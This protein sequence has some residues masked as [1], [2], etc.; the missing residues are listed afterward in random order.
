MDVTMR[1]PTTHRALTCAFVGDQSLVV[2][3]VDI[4]RD[5]GLAV[6]AVASHN[7]DV[8]EAAAAHGTDLVELGSPSD[9]APAFASKQF[10]VL[11]S[12]A[13]LHILPDAVLE[14]ATTAINFHDGP[15]PDYAGLNVTSWAIANGE[16]THGVTWHLMTS[17]VDSGDV[18]ATTTFPIEPGDTAL[19][20]NARCFEAGAHS[21]GEVARALVGGELSPEPQPQRP[22]RMFRRRERPIVVVDPQRPAAETAR[23][24]RA[25]EVGER[26]VN[27]VG[28]AHLVVDGEALVV[29]AAESVEGSGAVPGSVTTEESGGLRIATVD[30]DL[31]V[32]DVRRPDGRPEQPAGTGVARTTD[33]AASLTEH[34]PRLSD[35]EDWWRGRLGAA[36][37]SPSLDELDAALPRTTATIDVSADPDTVAAALSLVLAARSEGDAVAMS[38]SDETADRLAGTLAPLLSPPEIRVEVDLDTGA[39]AHVAAVGEQLRSALEHGPFLTDLIDRDPR[40]RTHAVSP[41]FL[42]H[43]CAK[44]H[45]P[46]HS[47]RCHV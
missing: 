20:L 46:L 37:E 38:V 28:S 5:A 29:A 45:Y 42:V 40:L 41:S 16:T 19:S 35:H 33:L 11:V 3:C 26:V 32:R 13:Y 23:A 30:G 21:F 1:Q 14:R 34:D 15:L 2:R 31:V 17:D 25:V 7:P 9:L 36:V 24:I 6:T 10:D 47:G 12:V 39:S 8:L 18:V 44:G 22:G 43:R 27:T 4:A